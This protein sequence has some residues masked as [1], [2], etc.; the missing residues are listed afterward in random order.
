MEQ[1]PAP[2][3]D[4][5]SRSLIPFHE[6]AGGRPPS[7]TAAR[8]RSQR[9]GAGCRTASLAGMTIA[10]RA[11][12]LGVGAEVALTYFAGIVSFA[13]VAVAVAA[14][15]LD[16]PVLLLAVAIIGGVVRIA[17]HLG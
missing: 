12:Q 10:V 7:S 2:R 8:L 1:P 3:I 4:N 17:R 5:R 6:S 14:I 13:A 9:S 11:R 15:G 16:V